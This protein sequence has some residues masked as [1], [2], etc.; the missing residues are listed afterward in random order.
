MKLPVANGPTAAEAGIVTVYRY[1][2]PKR[3]VP[4]GK[5]WLA[6]VTPLTVD[7]SLM[8]AAR[9]VPPMPHGSSV[10]CASWKARRQ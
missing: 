8:A 3:G 7:N 9:S 1:P 5:V 4:A 10:V 6:A 2:W